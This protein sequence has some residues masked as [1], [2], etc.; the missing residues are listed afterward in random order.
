MALSSR[1]MAAPVVFL[2]LLLVA[3]E[4]RTAAAGNAGYCVSQS[5]K[6][7]GM[8]WSDNNC[9]KVCATENFPAGECKIDSVTRKCFCK[10]PC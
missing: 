8:C 5:H 6:F 10:K 9:E 4:M 3:T 2:L 7:K 1:R